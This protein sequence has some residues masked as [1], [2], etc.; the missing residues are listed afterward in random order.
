MKM[1]T[2][3][4]MAVVLMLW[5]ASLVPL[6]A[7]AG[8]ASSEKGFEQV[9]ATPKS[10]PAAGLV[11][12]SLQ[13]CIARIPKEASIGQRMVAEQSCGRDE[14]ERKPLEVVPAVRN[15]RHYR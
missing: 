1:L 14:S 2:V 11:E 12:D 7:L 10:S 3:A 4:P 8:E 6:R 13:A 9:D 15:I 5:T